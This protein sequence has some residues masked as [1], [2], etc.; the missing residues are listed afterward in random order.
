MFERFT[1][2]ARRAV[3]L[4]QEEA[5]LLDHNY[6][7]T[8]HLLL[9]LLHEGEGIGGQVLTSL[10]L[11]LDAVRHEVE[12]FIGETSSSPSAHMPFTPRAKRS[13]EYALREA[14]DLQ[15]SY[16]GTEHMLLG[17]LREGEGVSTQVLVA[18]HVDPPGVR[19]KVL[20]AIAESPPDAAPYEVVS[21]H[22]VSEALHRM[23]ND[24]LERGHTKLGSE[25]L[26]LWIL[27]NSESGAV[28]ALQAEGVDLAALQSR[29]EQ[30]LEEGSG[31][32]DL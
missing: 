4:A 7:G 12:E 17:L 29:L 3:V 32:T 16:I 19:Q 14:L 28:R 2:R 20:Q 10:G 1:D 9:G 27:Q 18:L 31:T 26:L 11:R 24:A 21:T 23:V 25:H 8:E 30:M 22:V 6:I 15:H 13:L 5:R